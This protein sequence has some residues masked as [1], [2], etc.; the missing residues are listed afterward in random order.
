MRAFAVRK[1]G[2]TAALQDLPIPDAAD[3]L[4]V[5]VKFAG[6]NPIDYK[7]IER[8]AADSVYPF[9][10]GADFSGLVERVPDGHTDFK[11]GDRIFGMARK[12]G[13]YADYTSVAA[14]G[15]LPV[16]KIPDGVTDEQA[17]A[18]PIPAITALGSLELLNLKPSQSLLVTG[19]S[20]AVGGY[21]VQMARSRG[22][23]VIGTVRGD[24]DEARRLGLDEI[25]DTASGDV[26]D[27]IHKAHTD[28]VDAVLDLVNGPDAIKRDAEILKPGGSLV[29]TIYAA[30]EKWFAERKIKAHN[31][32]GN[33]NPF[34]TPQGLTQV[35]QMLAAGTITARI[36][37]TVELSDAGQLLEKLKKGGLRGK[38]LIHVS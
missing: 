29:S 3:A 25:Y 14:G 11:V 21:A 17:A 4:L 34:S 19:A 20:G 1:F 26:F 8:L 24:A 2:E 13:S 22:V 15:G 30:D 33:T 7:L 6:V 5:S 18:L 9:V 36:Q 23:R 32:V 31:I 35:V 27:A 38:A 12:H 10:L 28:G 16:A 37:S